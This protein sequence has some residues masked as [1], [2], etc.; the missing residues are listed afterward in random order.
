MTKLK[1]YTGVWKVRRLDGAWRD[2]E[3]K[4]QAQAKFL[5]S[6]MQAFGISEWESGHYA[7][8]YPRTVANTPN[9]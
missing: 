3:I 6:N 2:V 1:F 7:E 9:L 4:N 5:E 8:K